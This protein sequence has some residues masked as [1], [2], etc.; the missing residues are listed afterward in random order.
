MRAP[1]VSRYAPTMKKRG[2]HSVR[3]ISLRYLRRHLFGRE[4]TSAGAFLASLRFLGSVED[5]TVLAFCSFTKRYIFT[6][7]SRYVGS[8][9]CWGI[10]AF[11]TDP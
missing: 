2:L 5:W 9:I 11:L 6:T 7:E 4:R 1:G 8:K 10:V 3:P